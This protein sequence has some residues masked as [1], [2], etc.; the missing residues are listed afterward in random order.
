M[1]FGTPADRKPFHGE[2]A[3][4]DVR[5]SVRGSNWIHAEGSML[6]EAGEMNAPSM[7]ARSNQL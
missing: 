1:V 4:I 2:N 6:R 7:G 3:W 5:S